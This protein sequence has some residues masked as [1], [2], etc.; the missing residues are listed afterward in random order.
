MFSKWLLGIFVFVFL[1]IFSL[2][3]AV[4]KD[5]YV[6]GC[7]MAVTGPGSGTYAQIKQAMDIYFD[8]VNARGGINGHPV[9]IIVADNAGQPS[10]AAAHAKKFVTQDKVII[11]MLVSLSSTYAPVVKVTKQY[12]VPLFYGGAVCPEACYPPQADPNQFCSTAFGAKFDSQFA[13]PFI[14]EQAK[15]RL[16]LG[17]VAMNIP[18]SRGGSIT[19]NGSRKREGWRSWIKWPLLHRPRITRLMRRRSRM[20]GRLGCIPGLHGAFR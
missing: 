13:I 18:I 5:A 7:S 8:D 11:V 19:R 20:R 6:I 12:G 16:K 2:T 9:K 10:K 15:G 1:A 3:P 17:L 4:A 14:H